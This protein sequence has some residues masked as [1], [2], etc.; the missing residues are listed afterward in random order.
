MDAPAE[1]VEPPRM[2]RGTKWLLLFAA[3]TLIALAFA[4]QFNFTQARRGY[5][6]T[7]GFAL[8][9]AL[10]DWYLI[11]LLSFPT[12][13]L[14]RRFHFDAPR[15]RRSLLVHLVASAA[16]AVLWVVLRVTV[17]LV[18]SR[19]R[20]PA[21]Y[22]GEMF[23]WTLVRSFYFNLLVYWIIV[24][25]S[26]GVEY[27]RRYREREVRAI[28]L[29]KLVAQARLQALRSQL[30]PHFLFNTLNSISSLMHKDVEAADRM[31]VRLSEL[32]R[33]A[34]ESVET[35]EVPLRDELEFLR[36]YLEIEQIRF[37]ARL[38]V[39]F[40]IPA[41][42]LEVPVPNLLL[43]PL[44]ENAIKHG[45]APRKQPGRVEITA[46]RDGSHLTVLVRDNGPGPGQ[47]T[48][49]AGVGLANTRARL[50]HLYGDRHRFESGPAAEGGFEVRLQVPIMMPQAAGAGCRAAGGP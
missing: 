20:L 11:A 3:W 47:G 5:I 15:W 7:W 45:V 37:G 31:I 1:R 13:W 39:S 41:D 10:A 24:G 21:F 12:L 19:E 26:H 22:F 43:Q 2:R 48:S 23:H 49:G 42:T 27:Y 33:L 16:F 36:R 4:S 40:D 17:E 25:A 14:A 44:V 30:N 8:T 28:G 32:L 9:T 46:R 29:E 38:Q 35:Q 50:E 34:L 18:R 6:V